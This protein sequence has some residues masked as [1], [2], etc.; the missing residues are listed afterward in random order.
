MPAE[1]FNT[2]NLRGQT[3][4]S[5]CQETGFVTTATALTRYQHGRGIN[6][7]RCERVGDRP[8]NW[9]KAVP[10]TICEH[11]AME[12]KGNRW[13]FRQHKQTKGFQTTKEKAA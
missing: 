11:C 12:V 3:R 1:T 10:R 6:S 7:S 13:A 9:I 2:Q 8:T 5:P 4:L